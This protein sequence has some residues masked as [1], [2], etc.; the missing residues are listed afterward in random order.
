MLPLTPNL[1][2]SF[3]SQIIL[4]TVGCSPT[5]NKASV[6]LLFTSSL[7]ALNQEMR[8]LDQISSSRTLP[9]R[10]HP[11]PPP[12]DSFSPSGR[13][14]QHLPLYKLTVLEL[15]PP[16][17]SQ[18]ST[19]RV[20]CLPPGSMFDET[21]RKDLFRAVLYNHGCLLVPAIVLQT[22]DVY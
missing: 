7:L 3:A 2:A 15:H 9:P 14:L 1:R 11:C 21:N 10:A 20:T 12:C 18:Q 19:G 22:C 16:A 4:H 17:A 6:C 5:P 13:L 8:K